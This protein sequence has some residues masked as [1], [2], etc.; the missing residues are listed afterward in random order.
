MHDFSEQIAFSAS[1]NFE[2]D[3][4]GSSLA[5]SGDGKTLAVGTGGTPLGYVKLYK[6]SGADWSE[7][8]EILGSDPLDESFASF[9]DLSDDGSILVLGSSIIYYYESI[10]SSL[11]Q[12]VEFESYSASQGAVSGDGGT[13]AFITDI[14]KDCHIFER[15]SNGTDYS[16]DRVGIPISGNWTS[17]ALNTNGSIMI[18]GSASDA[19]DS[20]GSAFV[21]QW[22]TNLTDVSMSDWVQMGGEITPDDIEEDSF[23]DRETVS[24]TSDG[25]TVSVGSGRG[26]DATGIVRVYNYDESAETWKQRGNDLVGDTTDD[27]GTEDNLAINKMSSDG[28]YLVAGSPLHGYYKIFQ[29]NGIDYDVRTTVNVGG[30]END[31][32]WVDISD[33]G[34]LVANGNPTLDD[35]IGTIYLYETGVVDY[36]PAFDS[37]NYGMTSFVMLAIIPMALF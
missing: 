33:D 15:S 24:I 5:I 14:Q 31:V 26:A 16:F 35:G 2:G 23:G 32:K 34:G 20:A 8:Q 29:W 36:S 37:L 11:Y 3:G 30:T 22:K 19:S 4:F 17:V 12:L 28:N 6:R 13:I 10:D 21:F 18:L 25:L 27:D 1:G 7:F 9:V